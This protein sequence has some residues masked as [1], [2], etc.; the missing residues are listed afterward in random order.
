MTT[1]SARIGRKIKL[2]RKPDNEDL[3]RSLSGDLMEVT[4]VRHETVIICRR[5]KDQREVIILGDDGL[6]NFRLQ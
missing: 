4:E 2:I 5:L 6:R 1:Q 3:N